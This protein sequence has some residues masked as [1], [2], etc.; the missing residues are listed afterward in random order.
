[1]NDL[2]SYIRSRIPF[3][4]VIVMILAVS[5][6]LCL[7]YSLPVSPFVHITYMSIAICLIAVA[8]DL[9]R[10]KGRLDDVRRGVISESEI[11]PKDDI[12]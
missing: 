2:K 12:E 3:A 8:V 5:W 10:Y 11:D 9:I 1:M 7:L 4:V 6:V